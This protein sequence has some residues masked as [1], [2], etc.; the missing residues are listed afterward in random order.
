MLVSLGISLPEDVGR[1]LP[2][3][4]NA[5][6]VAVATDLPSAFI[7]VPPWTSP[8][9]ALQLNVD[10]PLEPKHDHVHGPEPETELAAPEVHSPKAGA[11]DTVVPLLE[12]QAP[13]TGPSARLAAQE[14]VAPPLEPGHDHVHGPDPET[15]LAAPE[16][17]SPEAGA[18]DAVVP[19]LEP[20]APLT[21]LGARLAA[22]DAVVPPLEPEQDHAHGPEPETEL[23]EPD[24]HS[25]EAG[26]E[27]T[28]VPLLAPQEPLT[29]A[30]E[31]AEQLVDAPPLWPAQVQVHGPLPWTEPTK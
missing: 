7:A 10:P 30:D 29:E 14:A 12:P 28:V 25:P 15:E 8:S 20:Q 26:A 19:L 17:H 18:E 24:V 22:Q 11:V 21:G 5:I 3:K 4:P 2:V 23:A 27:E 16:V 31:F 1:W 13:L 9:G 6:V